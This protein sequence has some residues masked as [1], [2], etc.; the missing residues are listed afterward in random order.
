MWGWGPFVRGCGAMALILMNLKLRVV[1]LWNVLLPWLKFVVSLMGPVNPTLKILCLSVGR[2]MVQ[3]PWSS[4]CLLGTSLTVCSSTSMVWRVC[5]TASEK[6]TGPTTSWH[7]ALS[8]GPVHG[9]KGIKKEPTLS[10]APVVA[11]A[12]AVYWSETSWL[13]S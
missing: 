6:R 9:C 13:G 3:Y 12:T 10:K 7:T 4:Y 2:P 5:L 8:G 11:V 1:S